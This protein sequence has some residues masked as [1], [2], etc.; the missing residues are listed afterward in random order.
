[1]YLARATSKRAVKLE[2]QV[3]VLGVDDMG[4]EFNV[5][6]RIRTFTVV[7]DGKG[8]EGRR[9]TVCLGVAPF[10]LHAPRCG[11]VSTSLVSYRCININHHLPAS[12]GAVRPVRSFSVE[13][14]DG[15]I[16]HSSLEVR[17][18]QAFFHPHIIKAWSLE[19]EGR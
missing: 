3:V 19:F 6:K 1:M 16:A 10:N 17:L 4:F 9:Q 5:S 15:P 7:E 14:P 11:L 13:R 18:V 12:G 8:K 2:E